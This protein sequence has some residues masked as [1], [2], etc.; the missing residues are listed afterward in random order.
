MSPCSKE[1]ARWGYG[2]ND[3]TAPPLPLGNGAPSRLFFS[4]VVQ[5]SSF[6]HIL[7]CRVHVLGGAV[8]MHCTYVRMNVCMYR[9]VCILVVTNSLTPEILSRS[10]KM[11]VRKEEK[12]ESLAEAKKTDRKQQL[13]RANRVRIHL[14]GLPCDGFCFIHF[15]PQV[16]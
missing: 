11:D 7:L 16:P 13:G 12:T 2:F 6:S 4:K 9:Y 5:V 14:C 1:T 3:S 8:C 15:L 10:S